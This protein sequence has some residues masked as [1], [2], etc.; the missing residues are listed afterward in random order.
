M[1]SIAKMCDASLLVIAVITV[2][3]KRAFH[4]LKQ[5]SSAPTLCQR[6]LQILHLMHMIH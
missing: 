6:V 2:I 4:S 1:D 5:C 3:A